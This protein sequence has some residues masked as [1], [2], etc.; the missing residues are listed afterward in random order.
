MKCF[1]LI[2]ALL[3]LGLASSGAPVQAGYIEED[4]DGITT[5]TL[6]ATIEGNPVQWDHER[7][8]FCTTVWSQA[9]LPND[10][11]GRAGHLRCLKPD[12]AAE[13]GL[14]PPRGILT[15]VYDWLIYGS[16]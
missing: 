2:V 13:Y 5:F 1:L 12:V 15:R 4:G 11:D 3:L 6:R 16:F 14:A 10:E 7:K 9:L 8:R